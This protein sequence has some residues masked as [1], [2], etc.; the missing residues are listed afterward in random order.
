M[1]VTVPADGEA[2][3]GGGERGRGPRDR[4]GAPVTVRVMDNSGSVGSPVVTPRHDPRPEHMDAP[5]HTANPPMT[6][7]RVDVPR[8]VQRV[9]TPHS[10]P[11]PHV[12]APHSAPAPHVSAPAAPR[13][14]APHTSAPHSGGG[15]AHSS[16]EHS[17]K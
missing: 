15:E 12:E 6:P 16:G 11:T 10:A 8:S 1:V 13:M 17:P 4:D 9:E 14:E 3:R 5:G 2:L 7:P